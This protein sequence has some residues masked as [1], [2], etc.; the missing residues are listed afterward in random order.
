MRELKGN[1]AV[2]TGACH[3]TIVARVFKRIFLEAQ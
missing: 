1:V 3:G 2:M